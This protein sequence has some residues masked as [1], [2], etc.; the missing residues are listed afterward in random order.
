MLVASVTRELSVRCFD[1][2][3]YDGKIRIYLTLRCN[4]DCPFCVDNYR[5]PDFDGYAYKTRSVEEWSSQINELGR[6]VVFTGGEPLLYRHAGLGLIDLVNRI[7]KRIYV[8]VYSNIGIDMTEQLAQL[9]RPIRMLASFHPHEAKVPLFMKNIDT[10]KSRDDIS[11]VVHIIDS[12]NNLDHPSVMELREEMRER[13]IPVGIDADQEFEGSRRQFRLHAKC[14][15]KIV[16]LAPDGT[17]FQCVGKLTRRADHLEN[18][19]DD[20]L[21]QD[22]NVV[23]CH[24]YGYCA[25]SDWLGETTMEVL[26][27]RQ[28]APSNRDYR[29][30]T[31]SIHQVELR[32]KP[33]EET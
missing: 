17:R 11:L 33:A 1:K 30:K 8:S 13:S 32:R 16:L 19:F 7:H 31:Y 20:G 9:T 5:K 14:S 18:I 22:L 28:E 26:D 2:N 3:L 25:A 6:D 21:K 15:R 24:E 29:R 10:I 23:D 12:G 4:Y 27:R